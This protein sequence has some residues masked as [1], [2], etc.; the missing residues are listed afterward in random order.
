M[1]RWRVNEQEK[2]DLAIES[3]RAVAGRRALVDRAWHAPGPATK[4]LFLPVIYIFRLCST[5]RIIMSWPIFPTSLNWFFMLKVTSGRRGEGKHPLVA[6]SRPALP[7]RRK[8]SCFFAL[9]M[10][11]KC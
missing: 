6:E 4:I 7:C 5:H 8:S 11:Q 9:S 2:E 3:D 10:H 1:G